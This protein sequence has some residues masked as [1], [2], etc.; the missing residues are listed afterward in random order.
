[1]ATADREVVSFVMCSKQAEIVSAP[2][3]SSEGPSGSVGVE[4][5][6]DVEDMDVVLL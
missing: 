1:M 6:G 2:V 3:A 4:D 5:V